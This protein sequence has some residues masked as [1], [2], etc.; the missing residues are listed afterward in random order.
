MGNRLKYRD[1]FVCA[2]YKS[3][4]IQIK[5]HSDEGETK[6][7]AIIPENTAQYLSNAQH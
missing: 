3:A 5:V 4:T 1:V 7:S 2:I 6:T